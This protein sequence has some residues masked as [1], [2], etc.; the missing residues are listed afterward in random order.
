MVVAGELHLPLLIILHVMM[1]ELECPCS[2][3]PLHRISCFIASPIFVDIFV[4]M[5]C[6]ALKLGTQMEL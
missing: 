5:H 4:I 6:A 3:H 1:K 2:K